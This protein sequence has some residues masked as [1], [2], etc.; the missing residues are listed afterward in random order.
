MLGVVGGQPAAGEPLLQLLE[1]DLSLLVNGVGQPLQLGVG[2]PVA[3]QVH[4]GG[5][6]EQVPGHLLH[7]PDVGLVA[8]R[9]LLGGGS[10]AA[11]H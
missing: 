2:D 9:T 8:G 7:E 1:V 6:L 3:G 5:P 11:G 4:D 10:G